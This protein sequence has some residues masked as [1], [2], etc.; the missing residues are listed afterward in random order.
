PLFEATTVTYHAPMTD[1]SE[2]PIVTLVVAVLNEAPYIGDCLVSI[3]AQDYPAELVEVLVYDG[4]STDG[5]VEIAERFT[6]GHPGWAVRPNPRRIQ[7]AAWNA[8]IEAATGEIV[9]IVSGHSELAPDYI[10]SAVATLRET[11]ADM[12]GGPVR[13]IGETPVG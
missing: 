3:A 2:R 12:V 10:S 8:G 4:G 11:G 1:L 13:A 5:S 6:A 7:A 9:G